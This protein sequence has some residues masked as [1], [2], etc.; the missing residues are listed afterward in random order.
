MK[1]LRIPRARRPLKARV[2]PVGVGGERGPVGGDVPASGQ[3]RKAVPTWAAA[4]PGRARRHGRR[5]REPAGGDQGQVHRVANQ[6]QQR[7]QRDRRRAR[8][9]RTT[10]GGRRPRRPARRGRR[11]RPRREGASPGLVTVTQTSL[12][13]ARR[14]PITAARG[15]AEGEG[16]DGDRLA[17]EQRELGVPVVVVE[18]G[19]PR[20]PR[21]RPRPP[22][23]RRRPRRP[24]ESA[25]APGTKRLTPNGRRS[26]RASPRAPRAGRRRSGS[27]RPGT[28]A[29]RRPRPPRRA[30][31][32]TARPP[33]GRQD[34]R[35][36]ESIEHH[37]ETLAPGSAVLRRTPGGRHPCSLDDALG[38]CALAVSQLAV[39]GSSKTVPG[40]PSGVWC[41]SLRG[42]SADSS[43]AARRGSCDPFWM[44][45]PT[46]LL[47]TLLA[48]L[49]MA[50]SGLALLTGSKPYGF[51]R[52]RTTEAPPSSCTTSTRRSRRGTRRRPARSLALQ[53]PALAHSEAGGGSA[54]MRHRRRERQHSSSLPTS[55]W[56]GTG[57]SWTPGVTR[58]SGS[59]PPLAGPEDRW[60]VNASDAARGES[61]P[62][63]L[64][65]S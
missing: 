34:D 1:R 64:R 11:L 31:A 32:S 41:P 47:L 3:S 9:R 63:V 22:A 37:M 17:A 43:P 8:R 51:R 49:A 23:A 27:R 13:A 48:V 25:G 16:D 60:R 53:L 18:R 21:R 62:G 28:R 39:P 40:G 45:P 15:Q 4:A 58:R 14:R 26:A 36:R 35:H 42:A 12:P 55:R 33:S 20:A 57:Q 59:R 30:P 10:R 52:N 6:L 44:P 24:P 56:T 19:A 61:L 54:R 2:S 46:P 7:Q 50:V 38:V 65:G 5:G 29:H